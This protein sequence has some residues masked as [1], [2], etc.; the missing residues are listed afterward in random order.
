MRRVLNRMP[1]GWPREASWTGCTSADEANLSSRIWPQRSTSSNRPCAIAPKGGVTLPAPVL[2]LPAGHVIDDAL[3]RQLAPPRLNRLFTIGANGHAGSNAAAAPTCGGPR[4]AR[5]SGGGALRVPDIQAGL[6]K[7]DRLA[8]RHVEL[9]LDLSICNRPIAPVTGT[10][11]ALADPHLAWPSGRE[12]K[13]AGGDLCPDASNNV[14]LPALA[15]D[16]APRRPG[17][18]CRDPRLSNAPRRPIVS[19]AAHT[20]PTLNDETEG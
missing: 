15:H 3:N 16:R 8:G 18:R 14:R 12:G 2:P 1:A 6:V 17:C 10:A 19:A 13:A 5:L 20:M 4:W 11:S 7:P 9:L